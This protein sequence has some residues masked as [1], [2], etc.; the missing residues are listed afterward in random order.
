M[1]LRHMR[2]FVA[3]AET[4]NFR[5]AAEQLHMSTPPLSV[6]I[7]NLEREIGTDLLLRKGGR[8]ELTDAGRVF[9]EKAR[10]I[11]ADAQRSI[12]LAQQAA[13]GEIGRLSIG[14]NAVA[15][16]GVLPNI[17]PAFKKQWPEVHLDLHSLRTPQQVEA[18]SRGALDLGF[19]CPP[20]AT[21]AFDIQDLTRQPFV[22]VLSSR[23]PLASANTVSF[24]ALSGQPLIMY[25]RTLDP[26]SFRQIEQHFLRAGAVMK[27]AYELETS[28]SMIAL[29]AA[30][31]GCCIVPEYVSSLPRDG[32]VYKPLEPPSIVRTLSIAKSKGRAG[33]VG[34]FYRFAVDT[35]TRANE[36]PARMQRFGQQ[37][38][39]E[40]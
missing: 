4:L 1:E 25:S 9:L 35:L 20:I 27:V 23:H 38:A 19:V 12:I 16:S 14:Y 21:D 39:P 22:A 28:Q 8:I 6:Q 36:Y 26:H 30:E 29:V 7:R 11:L 40:S 13:C 31:N 5:K 24:A 3:L 17:V 2:Y 32:I 37:H 34:V 18:L 10:Q 15:E 33:L